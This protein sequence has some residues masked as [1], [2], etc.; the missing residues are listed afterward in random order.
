ME[1]QIKIEQ[2][3][4]QR[5]PIPHTWKV[6]WTVQNLGQGPLT[7][8][9]TRLP[10]GKFRAEEIQLDKPLDLESNEVTR[11]DLHVRCSEAP[12]S[13][14]ENAFLIM[15]TIYAGN[16]W[17]V[18]ARFRV[19]IDADGALLTTTE[20]ITPQLVGFSSDWRRNQWQ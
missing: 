15:R 19:F 17:L 14:V 13:V 11:L 8:L 2:H 6:T 18:L 10:H 1:P 20:R 16:Q 5:S 9:A 3:S 4:S 12:G 7:I